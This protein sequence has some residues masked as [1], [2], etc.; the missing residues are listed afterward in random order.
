MVQ[1]SVTGVMDK[2]ATVSYVTYQNNL[3]FVLIRDDV[4]DTIVVT[5]LEQISAC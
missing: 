3:I 5:E 2:I 4:Q 1:T